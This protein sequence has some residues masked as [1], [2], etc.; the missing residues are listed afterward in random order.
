MDVRNMEIERIS[1]NRDP[2]TAGDTYAVTTEEHEITLRVRPNGPQTRGF[3]IA[4]VSAEPPIT[5]SRYYE[6]EVMV[7][8]H[9]VVVGEAFELSTMFPILSKTAFKALGI[10]ALTPASR[11]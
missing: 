6:S 10:T 2:A 8:D 4:F 5:E 1:P 9:E 3:M 7:K 11:Q